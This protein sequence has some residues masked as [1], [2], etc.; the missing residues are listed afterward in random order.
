MKGFRNIFVSRWGN[1]DIDYL[2]RFVFFFFSVRFIVRCVV[3]L[4]KLSRLVVFLESRLVLD[5]EFNIVRILIKFLFLFMIL[6]FCIGYKSVIGFNLFFWYIVF[7]WTFSFDVVEGFWNWFWNGVVFGFKFVFVLLV[8]L[9]C[10]V[11]W[12]FFLYLSLVEVFDFL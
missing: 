6:I 4:F 7:F 3:D 5:L 1:Y 11:R 9:L 12:W 8:F 10:R 2:W